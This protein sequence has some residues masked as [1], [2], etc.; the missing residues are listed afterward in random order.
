MNRITQG[1]LL[2]GAS[3]LSIACGKKNE[4]A[5]PPPMPVDVQ[6]PIVRIQQTYGE[7]TGT[8]EGMQVVEIRA[9]VEG[10][11]QEVS[12]EFIP[13]KVVEKGTLLFKIDDLPY[14]AAVRN[15]KAELAKAES[16]LSIANVTLERRKRAGQGVSQLDV[17]IAAADV[18]AAKAAVQAAQAALTTAEEDLSFCEIHA[19][20]T[21]RIS[22]LIV[23]Q[24][25][26]VGPGAESLLCTIVEDDKM[27]IYF[28]ANERRA[29]KYLRRRQ[30]LEAEQTRP[31]AVTITLADGQPYKHEAQIDI[32]D[33][34]IDSETGTLRVRAIAPNPEGTLADGLFVKVN[35]PK[36]LNPK[37]AVLVP[38]VAIQKD[39][40][41]DYVL[42]VNSE[43]TVVR[44]NVEV[45]D[46][47]ERLKIIT[48]GLKGD[49]HIIVKGLQR[50]REGAK[51]NPTLVE[52][53][54]ATNKSTQLP[55]ITLS[56]SY[57]DLDVTQLEEKVT[58]PLENALKEYESFD[59]VNSTASNGKLI[60][61]I[62]FKRGTNLE[63]VSNKLRAR[64]EEIKGKLPE[65]V[66]DANVLMKTH[67]V[68]ASN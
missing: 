68:E 42:K 14:R 41:G 65:K 1:I 27:R 16:S 39:L 63:E 48:D 12:P 26:L 11:L 56:A 19:P 47:V 25:N 13:G 9:R 4:F 5:P 37:E 40:G 43:N 57:E 18:Q 23:D 8:I 10:I 55:S 33:N 24:F 28:E 54:Q 44:V 36:D 66:K 38:A 31:P 2:L 52:Q 62:F 59:S 58:M 53:N 6:K 22:E 20:I 21:G 34:R 35:V 15:A 46:S 51:V 67:P 60:V 29:L 30:A 64:F 45:G 49:E 50:V 17:E 7:Y 32:A 3:L 61:T